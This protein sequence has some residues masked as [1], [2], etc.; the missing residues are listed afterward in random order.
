MRSKGMLSFLSKAQLGILS[1][2]S[3]YPQKYLAFNL[4]SNQPNASF[5]SA[6]EGGYRSTIEGIESFVKG[7]SSS[8]QGVS[9]LTNRMHEPS[10]SELAS[11]RFPLEASRND[12]K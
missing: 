10:R 2:S 4:S 7:I 11:S 12:S 8:Y 9:S 3:I 1:S 6:R 5:Y